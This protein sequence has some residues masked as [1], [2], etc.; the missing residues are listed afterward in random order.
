MGTGE[1]IRSI[2]SRA[3][4]SLSARLGGLLEAGPG[5]I[6]KRGR[7]ASDRAPSSSEKL[8]P[9]PYSYPSRI[10]QAGP[11]FRKIGIRRR[12]PFLFYYLFGYQD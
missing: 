3:A 10:N 7:S 2:Q 5:G 8:P 11:R 9:F 6:F 4:S 12:N 1:T